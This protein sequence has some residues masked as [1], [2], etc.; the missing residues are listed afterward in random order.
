MEATIDLGSL[1][2]V[3]R[4]DTDF[5]QDINSW[6]FMP[7]TVTCALS[8]D[9]RNYRS[10]GEVANTVPAVTWGPIVAPFNFR[11]EPTPARFVKVE[12][13]SVKT[14]PAWHKGSGGPAWIFIDEIAVR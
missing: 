10:I 12:A 9:G 2:T 13:V 5:L 6:V 1:Q 4:I 8:E 3:T 11:C 7:L 14:C